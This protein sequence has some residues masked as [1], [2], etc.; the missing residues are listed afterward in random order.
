M[1]PFSGLQLWT[2]H[3]SRN[4]P[5]L[6]KATSKGESS[7]ESPTPPNAEVAH[8]KAVVFIEPRKHP[9]SEFVLR[10]MRYFLPSWQ[11]IVVHGTD[12]ETFLKHICSSIR[13]DFQFI[14]A[15][16]GDLPTRSYNTLLTSPAFWKLLP[17][18]VLICQTDTLLMRPAEAAME[19][20][21]Q[22][23]YVFCGAP[24]SY[25]CNR[26]KKPLQ[27]KCG[28]MIDQ[29]VVC[30]MAPSMVG[31]GGLSYR[32]SLAMLD[33]CTTQCLSSEPCP[34]ISRYWDTPQERTKIPGTTNEDVFFCKGVHAKGHPM[35]SR[36][37]GLRFAIE[38]VAPFEW[39]GAVP[40]LGAHKPWA[41]LSQAL[42]QSL[43]NLVKY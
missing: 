6:R 35:P 22:S 16:V 27:E 26:C 5:M 9:S 29:E 30:S 1:D 34:L 21:I 25:T 33:I 39:D 10:N 8:A 20:L 32:D 15:K 7:K 18:H 17:R 12:N 40:A 23:E 11:I 19:K 38:Q 3:Q 43:L 41:Y 13:G 24:W 37:E 42:V 31:N 2:E 4:L 14:D 28:H 36:L